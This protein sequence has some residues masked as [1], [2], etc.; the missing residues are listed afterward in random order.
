MVLKYNGAESDPE[1]L[2]GGSIQGSLI[3][4]LLFV[5]ELSDA[6]MPVPSQMDES[7]V[8]SVSSPLLAV[9]DKEI[10]LKYVDD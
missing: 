6:G 2:P 1:C 10:R 8:V 4:I 7:D 5:I 9:T 3:G